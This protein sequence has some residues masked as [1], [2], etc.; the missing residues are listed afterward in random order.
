[1]TSHSH[2][3]KTGHATIDAWAE[4]AV[5]LP[6]DLDNQRGRYDELDLHTP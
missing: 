3:L 6:F 4:V 5:T 1:M 2:A